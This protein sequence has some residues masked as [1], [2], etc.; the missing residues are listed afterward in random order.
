MVLPIF[1]NHANNIEPLADD[2]YTFIEEAREKNEAVLIH[3]LKGMSRSSTMTACY[4]MK[5]G[6]C[7]ERDETIK[8]IQ[9]RHARAYP[10]ANFLKQLKS[11]E[12]SLG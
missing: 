1:D 11:F 9:K 2:V 4:L 8:Y 12:K 10:N 6:V 7:T 3:C 5:S